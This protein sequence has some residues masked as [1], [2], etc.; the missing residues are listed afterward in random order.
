M[1]E[2]TGKDGDIPIPNISLPILK[3]VIEYCTH[4]KSSNPKEI[5]KPLISKDLKENGVEEWDLKFIEMEKVDD[6]IDLIVAANF[7]DIE[8]LINLGCAKIASM[9]KGKSVE[10][11]REIFGIV[12]DFT[13][14]EEA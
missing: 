10:E 3:K 1:I 12:N 4:Y 8:G 13:P 6:L 9:I 7:L 2:D 5:K 14:E 11:I